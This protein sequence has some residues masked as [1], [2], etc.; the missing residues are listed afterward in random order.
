MRGTN[1]IAVDPFGFDLFPAPS[2]DGVVDP[3]HQLDG[4]GK[5]SDQQAQHEAARRQGR[6]SRP[7][8]DSMVT[9]ETLLLAQSHHTQG[10][11]HGAFAGRQNRS[12]HQDFGVLPNGLGEQGRKLYNQRQ[13]LGRQCQQLK[14]SRRKSGLQLMRPAVIFSKIK[15]GQSR[16]KRFI[17]QKDEAEAHGE[18]SVVYTIVVRVIATDLAPEMMADLQRR[19]G[20]RMMPLT[21]PTSAA[22]FSPESCPPRN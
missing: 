5:S 13:Q 11:G 20:I 16:A 3:H 22:D 17:Q 19:G 21:P 4:R 6:P 18:Y 7:I 1:R 9:L 12:D 15:N 10:G 2:F 8:Q 14:T